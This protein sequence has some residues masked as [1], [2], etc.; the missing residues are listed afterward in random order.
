MPRKIAH[1]AKL[2]DKA[3]LLPMTACALKAIPPRESMRMSAGNAGE[4]ETITFVERDRCLPTVWSAHRRW[5]GSCYSLL[6]R[7]AVPV[8][9]LSLPAPVHCGNISRGPYTPLGSRARPARP[10]RGRRARCGRGRARRPG[11]PRS[12]PRSRSAPPGRR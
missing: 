7:H 9:A 2:L 1:C 11:R 3:T 6:S 5:S 8:R 4:D 10:R 12:A